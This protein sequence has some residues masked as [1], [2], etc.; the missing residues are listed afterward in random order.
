MFIFAHLF[1]LFLCLILLYKFKEI[2]SLFYS[3]IYLKITNEHFEKYLSN[4][5]SSI[6]I[7]LMFFKEKPQSLIKKLEKAKI[8]EKKENLKRMEEKK[9]HLILS[10][11]KNTKNLHKTK[12]IQLSVSKKYFSFLMSNFF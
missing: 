1:F 8:N 10:M 11:E 5:Y 7:L 2:H 4:K 12:K 3:M 9:A 6:S